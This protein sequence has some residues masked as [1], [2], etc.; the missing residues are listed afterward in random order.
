MRRDEAK[1]K[2]GEDLRKTACVKTLGHVRENLKESEGACPWWSS[3]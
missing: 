1:R 2:Q 3:G